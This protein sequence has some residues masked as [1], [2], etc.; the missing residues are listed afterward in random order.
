MF[1]EKIRKY[2]D[3]KLKDIWFTSKHWDGN[4]PNPVFYLSPFIRGYEIKIYA[5]NENNIRC[6]INDTTMMNDFCSSSCVV[7][8]WEKDHFKPIDDWIENFLSI[9]EIKL[10][11]RNGKINFIKAKINV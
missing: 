2:V 8:N 4:N 7:S 6:E 10:E 5:I 1:E 9:P 3:D 11:I